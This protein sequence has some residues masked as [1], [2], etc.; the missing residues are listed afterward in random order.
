MKI[1]FL[2][3]GDAETRQCWSGCA[4]GFVGGLRGH[5]AEVECM[6]IDLSGWRRN[7]VAIRSVT[8]SR[9]VWKW[10]FRLGTRAFRH[11]SRVANQL[12]T[13]AGE[14]WDAV[15][16]TGATARLD[17]ETL[18]GRPYVIYCDANVRFAQ[19]GRPFSGVSALDEQTI[20]A[21]TRLEQA[22]YDRASRIWTWS[23]ALE[24]SFVRDFQQPRTKLRTIYAGANLDPHANH[25]ERGPEEDANRTPG[26]LFVGKD[27]RRK[28]LDILLEAFAGVRRVVPDATL[29]VVGAEPE[30][31]RRPG[32]VLH[33]FIPA[34]TRDGA[35]KMASLYREATVFCLPTRY[36]PFGVSFVEAM[37]AGLPCVG[38][39]SWA[40][41]EII[42][43][44]A[45]GWL[46]PDGDAS[47]LTQVLKT[48]LQAPD[49]CNRM[50]RNGRER[51]LREFTWNRVAARAME[52]LE[53]LRKTYK[54]GLGAA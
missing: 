37:L 7:W 32:V 48:A 9:D 21:V 11:R 42:E 24:E 50:G 6:D 52:D 26:I 35:D 3:E 5:G 51:A 14:D 2:A 27:Y 44:G 38:C 4:Q 33:G 30:W 12:V 41:P 25:S 19:Q 16:Q 46:V 31:A 18:A 15:I 40:M 1:L 28:G 20:E 39:R 17:S 10:R 43:E 45:T 13:Q 22:V 53:G 29:H 54:E 23:R 8:P 36:E 47:A 34:G 49:E